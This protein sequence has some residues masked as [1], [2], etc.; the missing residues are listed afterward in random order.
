ME[1]ITDEF[2][3]Q[4][5]VTRL[6]GFKNVQMLAHGFKDP[7]GIVMPGHPERDPEAQPDRP[8]DLKQIMIAGTSE[9]FQVK[10]GAVI[11]DLRHIGFLRRRHGGPESRS[12]IR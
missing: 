2:L 7:V 3:G 9:Y 6:D 8:V 12:V 1:M 5:A 4:C 11:V 10:L